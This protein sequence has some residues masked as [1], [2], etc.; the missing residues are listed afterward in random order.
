MLLLLI[1][2]IKL[3]STIVFV[4]CDI[5]AKNLAVEMQKS[6]DNLS[7]AHTLGKFNRNSQENA[8]ELALNSKNKKIEYLSSKSK[9]D[10][11]DI[12]T[13]KFEKKEIN[14]YFV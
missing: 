10:Q 5:L 7:H 2:Q 8:R 4:N 14:M 12:I 6:L 3:E 11:F 13:Q 9:V 1:S